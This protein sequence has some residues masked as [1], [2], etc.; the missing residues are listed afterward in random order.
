MEKEVPK[1]CGHCC[2]WSQW[3]GACLNPDSKRFDFT[4]EAEVSYDEEGCGL[5][6]YLDEYK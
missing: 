3:T 4:T 5:F 6:E 1:I 2:S